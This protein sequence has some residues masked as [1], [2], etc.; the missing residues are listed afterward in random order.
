VERG[1]CQTVDGKQYQVGPNILVKLRR[2][3]KPLGR[4]PIRK[5][6]SVAISPVERKILRKSREFFR[7]AM[8]NHRVRMLFPEIYMA[9]KEML[10]TAVRIEIGV[11][12][13]FS[14]FV[15]I[16]LKK[17]RKRDFRS[18]SC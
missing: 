18:N 14:I 8:Y 4:E 15:F 12:C 3:H 1:G 16:Y 13:R 10:F 7:E 17:K 9:I 2:R 6:Q 11:I 5:H